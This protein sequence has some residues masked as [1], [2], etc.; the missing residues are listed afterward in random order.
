[1]STRARLAVAVTLVIV[2]I[3]AYLLPLREPFLATVAWSQSHPAIAT[4]LFVLLHVVATLLFVPAS[5]AIVLAGYLFGF[6]AG[7]A[8]ALVSSTAALTASFLVGRF[9]ARDWVEEKSRRLPRFAALDAALRSRGF[10][11]VM[12]VRL[13]LVVPY[14]I[15]N[16]VCGLTAINLRTYLSGSAV[17]MLPMIIA[18][19]L[20]GGSIDDINVIL[21]GD[22]DTGV[23][24]PVILVV[25]LLIIAFVVVTISGMTTRVLEQELAK[26]QTAKSDADAADEQTRIR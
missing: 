9:L 16:Y 19:V 12:L 25:G 3:A 17:G 21:R 5:L 23:A 2:T 24:G 10:V 26:S 8:V 11:V 4:I 15:L 14:N 13:S 1:M 18:L 22:L 20:L 6:P 7:I